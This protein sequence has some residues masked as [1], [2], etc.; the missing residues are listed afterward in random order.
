MTFSRKAFTLI[1]LLIVVAII[2]ILAAIAVPNF[3]EAQTRAKVSRVKS[4][5]R[6]VG[7][8][9]EAYFVDSNAYPAKRTAAAPVGLVGATPGS[10][11][12]SW[13]PQ[14]S[15]S[16]GSSIT[17]PIAY[18]TTVPGDVF[19]LGSR[20]T[21]AVP[22]NNPVKGFRYFRSVS[23]PIKANL[24]ASGLGSD[25][26]GTQAFTPTITRFSRYG[27]WYMLSLGP[28]VDDD[29]PGFNNNYDPTNGTI[30]NGDII[31]SQKNGFVDR[32]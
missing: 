30:S 14:A 10:G 27:R 28:D 4:D 29:L 9:L 25:V 8:A 24:N 32:L 3:L 17:T 16:D 7:V 22:G 1:E 2:A 31:Y 11:L 15:D 26:D 19:N 20:V 5:M 21:G 18:L 13:V 12:G 6:S 23:P